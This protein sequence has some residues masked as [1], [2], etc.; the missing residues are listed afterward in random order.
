MKVYIT[1]ITAITKIG[2]RVLIDGPVIMAESFEH[3]QELAPD[4]VTVVGEFIEDDGGFNAELMEKYGNALLTFDS[5]NGLNE[6]CDAH[7][8]FNQEL[9]EELEGEISNH[10]NQRHKI[11]YP[12]E[13][14]IH[15]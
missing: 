5:V 2:E 9:I 12:K 1:E 15:N 11:F 4:W 8:R 7:E 6:T 13:I 3:A 14:L 10:F